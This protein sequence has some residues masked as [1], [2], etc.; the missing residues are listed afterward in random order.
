M[1]YSENNPEDLVSESIRYHEKQALHKHLSI[2]K[3]LSNES[4]FCDK[5]TVTTILRNLISNAIRFSP[6]GKRY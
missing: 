1:Q 2:K 5:Q 3:E 6:K 4:V